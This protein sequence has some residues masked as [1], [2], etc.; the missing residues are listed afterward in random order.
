MSNNILCVLIARGG[1]KGIKDK[2][3]Q[4]VSGIPMICHSQRKYLRLRK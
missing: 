3:I 4:T 1:S 2:N